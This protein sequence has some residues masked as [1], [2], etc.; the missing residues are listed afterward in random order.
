[1]EPA[2]KIL[3]GALTQQRYCRNAT[4]TKSYNRAVI[5][6]ELAPTLHFAERSP[7]RAPVAP[8]SL[9]PGLIVTVTASGVLSFGVDP[10]GI[11]GGGIDLTGD[12]FTATITFDTSRNS[13]T[14][15]TPTSVSF[16]GGTGV[17]NG[18]FDS[19]V[20]SASLTIAGHKADIGGQFRGALSQTL[21]TSA[22][23]DAEDAPRILRL[24]VF[25][26]PIPGTLQSFT[27]DPP[28][29]GHRDQTAWLTMQ[30]A[31][32]RSRLFFPEKL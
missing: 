8:P 2:E 6:T 19:P 17:N 24:E 16:V 25:G 21:D 30:S 5:E 31:A 29:S 28:V 11:F 26:S 22:E 14:T 23:Y 7:N 12:T 27:F 13:I 3:I 32:N 1:L 20:V 4:V 10:G 15:I 9:R 18:T